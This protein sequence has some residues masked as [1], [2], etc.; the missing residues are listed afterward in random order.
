[1]FVTVEVA[2]GAAG[3]VIGFRRKLFAPANDRTGPR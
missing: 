3:L 1:L 2:L